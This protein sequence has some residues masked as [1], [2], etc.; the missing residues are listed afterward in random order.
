MQATEFM[1]QNSIYHKKPIL[2]K[3]AISALFLAIAFV[4]NF[5]GKYLLFPFTAFL[6]FDFT[7]FIIAIIFTYIGWQY[8]LI[9]AL[10]FFIIAPAYNEF[11]Y[12]TLSVVGHFVL[13]V[14]QISFAS[15]FF[16]FKK[17]DYKSRISRKLK[18]RYWIYPL[19]IITLTTLLLIL[20]NIFAINPV[21]FQFF[22]DTEIKTF[23]D[24]AAPKKWESYKN[25]FFGINNYYLASFALYGVFNFVNLS[26]NYLFIVLLERKNKITQ[27]F[28]I[29]H[30]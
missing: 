30:N 15:L 26:L 3:L 19:A 17:I 14:T 4:L 8:G 1:E 12:S 18:F 2:L 22:G 11:G 29:L 24:L 28:K 9:V 20:L 6:K 23:K 5:F 10:T 25:L 16:L 7:I 27:I 13:F 21:Y